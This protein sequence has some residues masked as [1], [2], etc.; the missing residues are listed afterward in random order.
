MIKDKK[1]FGFL[2]AVFVIGL[3][4][5]GGYGVY[6]DQSLEQEILY[7]NLKEYLLHLPGNFTH[8]ISQLT[9]AGIPEISAS[10]EMDHGCA[11]FYP[12][13]PLWYLEKIS[14]YASMVIRYIYTFLISFSGICSLYFLGESI[15]KSKRCGAIMALMF[16]LSPR[17]FAEIHYNNKDV[18][19]LSLCFSL[20]YFGWKLREELSFKNVFMLAFVGAFAANTKIIGGFFFGMTGLFVLL[21]YLLNRKCT[22]KVWTN[23]FLC[24][25]LFLAIFV[26]ITPACW[27]DIVGYFVYLFNNAI[28]FTR[29]NDYVLFRGK[30]IH[31]AYTGIPR[32]YLPTMILLTTP[33]C[34]LLMTIVGYLR[35]FVSVIKTK[36]KALLEK[37]GFILACAITVVVPLMV[38][39][40]MATP[41][42]NGWR[43]FYFAYSAIIIGA[44]Y[45][46]Y[47]L[48]KINAKY[49]LGCASVYLAALAVGIAVNYP[50]EHSYFNVL[51]GKNM[52]S[53]YELDYWDVSTREALTWI[54]KTD[55][56]ASVGA[57]NNPT[58]WGIYDTIYASPAKVKEKFV[59]ANNWEEAEYIIVNPGYAYLYSVDPYQYVKEN[60][61]LVYQIK[62]YG[63]IVNEI[64]QKS[65]VIEGTK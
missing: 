46:Y 33:I 51:A 3:I 18:I 61:T 21:Y 30:P 7:M 42:Y 55:D 63:N 17:M 41:V 26:A 44:G 65:D 28:S 27:N 19:L 5:A 35:V 24:I 23:V 20:F 50:Q 34:I 62:S 58:M 56:N 25:M 40:I 36:G 22:L 4:T 9:N 53:Q 37:E 1:N 59:V 39:I 38:S 31:H 14:P 11:V 16:F 60:Y 52:E 47:R 48:E 10:I 13:F 57:L 15:F 2:F 6:L 49:A 64:Y 43:H 29:W 12:L 54:A 32:K 8:L 45:C